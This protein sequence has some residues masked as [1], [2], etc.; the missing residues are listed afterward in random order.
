MRKL[1]LTVP[2][3]GLFTGTRAMAA[4]GIG[5]LVA[6]RLDRT[7]R[8]AVGA[9]LLAVGLVTTIPLAMELVDAMRKARR[10]EAHIDERH[11][12]AVPA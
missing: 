2:Q 6:D 7:Q 3:V 8:R 10:R 11:R 12:E 1:M 4:L 5:L 9:T